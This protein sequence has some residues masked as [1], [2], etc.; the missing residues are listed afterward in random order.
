MDPVEIREEATIESMTNTGKEDCLIKVG[1][2]AKIGHDAVLN[3]DSDLHQTFDHIGQKSLEG[4]KDRGAAP[5]ESL[6]DSGATP[7]ESLSDSGATP[8]TFRGMAG[9]MQVIEQANGVAP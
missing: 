2:G 9:K 7:S 3:P 6:S 1:S 5:S 4:E 8:F